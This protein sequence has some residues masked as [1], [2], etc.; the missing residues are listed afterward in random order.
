MHN[1][2][3]V[4]KERR[5]RAAYAIFSRKGRR[6]PTT[7]HAKKKALTSMTSHAWNIR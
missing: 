6:N 7:R 2:S 1:S 3:G 4:L 5:P